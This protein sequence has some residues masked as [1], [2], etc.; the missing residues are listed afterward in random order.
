MNAEPPGCKFVQQES[1]KTGRRDGQLRCEKWHKA[2]AAK[3]G[4]NVVVPVS[5][6]GNSRMSGSVGRTGF[7]NERVTMTAD[8]FTCPSE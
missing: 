3:A 6:G 5:I 8:Y 2:Q 1:C 7:H 4:A